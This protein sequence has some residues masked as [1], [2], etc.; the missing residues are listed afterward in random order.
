MSSSL[1]LD[2]IFHKG[3]EQKKAPGKIPEA[4]VKVWLQTLLNPCFYCKGRILSMLHILNTQL[5][6]S[7][8]HLPDHELFEGTISAVRKLD[9]VQTRGNV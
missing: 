2:H 9:H 8:P 6:Y 3:I 1:A 7:H 5:K 4:F